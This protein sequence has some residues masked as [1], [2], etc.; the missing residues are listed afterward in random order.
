[1]GLRSYGIGR[2][3]LILRIAGTVVEIVAF[4]TRSDIYER[5]AAE[6]GLGYEEKEKRSEY[7]VAQLQ[8]WEYLACSV[9]PAHSAYS[10]VYSPFVSLT[11]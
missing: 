9:W 10:T 3:R 7:T 2:S 8:A 6:L 1:V 5:A 4:G 11:L